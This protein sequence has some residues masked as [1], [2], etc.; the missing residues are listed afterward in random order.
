MATAQ[1]LNVVQL[2]PK[3]LIEIIDVVDG[4]VIDLAQQLHDLAA[5]SNDGIDILINS[6]G[7]AIVPGYMFTDAMDAARNKGITIR[8]AV[9]VLAASMAFNMLAHCDERYALKHAALLFHPPR[10]NARGPMTASDLDQASADLKRIIRHTTKELVTMVGMPYKKF[11]MHFR[12]ETLWTAEQLTKESRKPWLTIV[13]D[14]QGSKKVFTHRKPSLFSL[15]GLKSSYEII[16]I[17]EVAN[18]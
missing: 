16:H 17:S 1:S 10:I 14:I 7:G 12:Q 3:R 9:G 18:D 4:S 11:L 13:A 15:F 5:N 8:C 2:N 6:P